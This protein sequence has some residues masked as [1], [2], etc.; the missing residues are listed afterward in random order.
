MQSAIGTH[1]RVG[2]G[3]VFASWCTVD[4][5]SWKWLRR[6]WGFC[7]REDR[8]HRCH[9]P[10]HP[11]G[12]SGSDA[13]Y[14]YVPEAVLVL[15]RQVP[16]RDFS[17]V[18]N[19]F[20]AFL[21]PF[22][23]MWRSVGMVCLVMVAAEAATVAIYMYGRLSIACVHGAALLVSSCPVA[24]YWTAATG[25]NDALVGLVVVAAIVVAC[26]SRKRTAGVI[27]AMGMSATA[28]DPV[29]VCS[30]RPTTGAPAHEPGAIRRGRRPAVVCAAAPVHDPS[31]FHQHGTERP[32]DFPSHQR[33]SL[34]RHARPRT[35]SSGC[36]RS[37]GFA[38]GFMVPT[39]RRST[40][41]MGRHGPAPLCSFGR[42][43]NPAYEVTFLLPLV[44]RI[45]T[46]TQPSGEIS[47]RH[48]PIDADGDRV[49]IGAICR[50]H[51][52]QPVVLAGAYRIRSGLKW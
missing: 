33:S 41:S 4:R 20:P 25:Y 30:A 1:L 21:A 39:A 12:G 45:D 37:P 13:G 15:H 36:T 42:N 50:A 34:V 7:C 17:T 44:H 6:P 19:L 43:A 46:G 52:Q 29:G 51:L 18:F 22:V 16:G 9:L 47:Q 49:P 23:W 3:A 28:L 35:D 11:F 32:E 48:T 8:G 40:S 38:A 10:A 5:T 26:R 14:A 2:G 27:L 24:V 31:R